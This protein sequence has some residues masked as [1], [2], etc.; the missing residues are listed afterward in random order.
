MCAEQ[1]PLC[2]ATD[3]ATAGTDARELLDADAVVD[4]RHRRAAVLFG[5]LDAHQA[6][7]GELR[8]QLRRKLLRLV[9]LHDVG[10]HLRFGELA[11]RAAQQLLLFGGTEVHS[12]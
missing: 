5:E 2:A 11:H 8:Q 7:R 4:R 9:P 6:E 1:R 3:S 12:R 10:T